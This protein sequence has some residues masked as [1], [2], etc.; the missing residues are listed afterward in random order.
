MDSR[1]RYCALCQVRLRGAVELEPDA[2]PFAALD[3]PAG[4]H[5][6]REMKA[7]PALVTCIG[8]TR[9]PFKTRASIEHLHPEALRS[10]VHAHLHLAVV[11]PVFH[12][13]GD[14][15]RREEPGVVELPRGQLG[16]EPRDQ[17]ASMRFR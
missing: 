13:V 15:L 14:Q 5:G 4:R 10:K 16:T 9:G 3:G 11:A 17:F 6:V 8:A 7:P 12:R 2:R 1:P